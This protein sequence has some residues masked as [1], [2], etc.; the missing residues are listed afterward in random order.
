MKKNY[1]YLLLAFLI[2]IF[3]LSSFKIFKWNKDN[4]LNEKEM[5]SI[6]NITVIDKIENDTAEEENESNLLLNVDFD[7]LKS[8]NNE[9]KGWIQVNNTNIDYPF[10]QHTDNNYY[11]NHSFYKESSK[12]G[13][14]F[15]DYRNNI[16]DFD[17]NTI[18][19]GHNR[20]NKDMFGSLKDVK[21][22]NWLS[23]KDNHIIKLS[24]EKNSTLWQVFSIYTITTTSDY[25]VTN[26]DNKKDHKDFIKMLVNR[27][28]YN[29]NIEVTTNDKILTLSTCN[30]NN[31]KMV[32]H[33]K[34]I[35]N[36]I[37]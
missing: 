24:T 2:L 9:V 1:Y 33:A 27:S 13:W 21:S 12:A 5:Q 7:N 30:G 4:N 32:L 31:Q 36:K 28:I 34:L 11:L 19:Y 18:I 26:F 8:I 16:N 10:V 35:T 14:V 17:D 22:E 20:A 15:L 23:N 37:K 25:L 29:F 6:Y 3:F